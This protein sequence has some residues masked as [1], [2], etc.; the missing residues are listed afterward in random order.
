MK[1]FLYDVFLFPLVDLT[2]WLWF[3]ARF[4]VVA[5]LGGGFAFLLISTVVAAMGKFNE[6]LGAI[7]L[8]SVLCGMAAG[9]KVMDGLGVSTQRVRGRVNSKERKEV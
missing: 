5:A 7:G 9:S 2:L 8:V 1:R 6:W 3:Y 4:A